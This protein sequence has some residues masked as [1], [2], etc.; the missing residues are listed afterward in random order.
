MKD[1]NMLEAR[2]YTY[3]QEYMNKFSHKMYILTYNNNY[4]DLT[5]QRA[6]YS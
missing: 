1:A 6:C 5:K 2:P 4:T 3:M